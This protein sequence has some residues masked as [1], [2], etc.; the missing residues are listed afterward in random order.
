LIVTFVELGLIILKPDLKS[1][2]SN[3]IIFKYSRKPVGSGWLSVKPSA[4]IGQ[5]DKACNL[6][7]KLISW[8]T[9]RQ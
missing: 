3:L 4:K 5:C 2:E 7:S 1:V 9:N 8:V 6:I